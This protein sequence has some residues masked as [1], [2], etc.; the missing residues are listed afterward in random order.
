MAVSA[1][2]GILQAVASHGSQTSE[3]QQLALAEAEQDSSCGLD[4]AT[5]RDEAGSA[6]NKPGNNGHT[7]Q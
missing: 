1:D 4:C 6:S 5:H 7:H 2:F 3:V